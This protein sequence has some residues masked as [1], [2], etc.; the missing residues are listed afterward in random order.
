[1][2]REAGL[3]QGGFGAAG[4]ADQEDQRVDE[5]VQQPPQVGSA[6]ILYGEGPHFRLISA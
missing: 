2:P 1:M 4:F 3:Q 6:A 5:L